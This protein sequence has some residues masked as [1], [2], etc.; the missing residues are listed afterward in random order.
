MKI[1]SVGVLAGFVTHSCVANAAEQYPGAASEL[2]KK[3]LAWK[4]ELPKE[5]E[6]KGKYRRQ[7]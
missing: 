4:A 5:V 3:L 1:L 7:Y 2:K 6:S